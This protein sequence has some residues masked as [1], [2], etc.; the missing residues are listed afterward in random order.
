MSETTRTANP[1]ADDETP[2]QAGPDAN[3]WKKTASIRCESNCGIEVRLGKPFEDRHG[4]P[5]ERIL[6]DKDHPASKGYTCEKALRLDHYQN[7]GRRL[8][9]PMRR[10]SEGGFEE[11]D[12][13]AA[14]REVAVPARLEP[15]G[16]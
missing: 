8:T 14:V 13:D 2:E 7:S 6:G 1:N 12:W 9:S 4:A 10:R 11:T 16:V 5:F 3:A 15:I